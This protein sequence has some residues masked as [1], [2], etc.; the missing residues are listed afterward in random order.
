[1]LV[2]HRDGGCYRYF[3]NARAP[4]V[5]EQHTGETKCF[6]DPVDHC[7]SAFALA[8]HADAVAAMNQFVHHRLGKAMLDLESQRVVLKGR[9]RDRLDMRRQLALSHRLVAFGETGND[10]QGDWQENHAQNSRYRF[11]CF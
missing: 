6:H 3:K 7:V 4:F 5:V 1:M 11:V 9:H 2:A 8:L 10:Q